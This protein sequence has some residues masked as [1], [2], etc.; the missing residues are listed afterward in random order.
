MERLGKPMRPR[1]ERSV[2]SE[3]PSVA[4][5]LQAY[6]WRAGPADDASG[7]LEVTPGENGPPVLFE[8]SDYDV[9]V[10][11]NGEAGRFTLS[12]DIPELLTETHRFGT[13]G[14][15]KVIH[16]R[17]EIGNEVGRF[18]DVVCDECSAEPKQ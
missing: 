3:L 8:T 16:Y 11:W 14:D 12:S 6:H 17:M 18:C 2:P 15:R 5:S 13:G 10:Q 4:T 7:L 9:Y 1:L